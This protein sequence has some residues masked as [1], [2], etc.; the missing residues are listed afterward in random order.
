MRRRSQQSLQSSHGNA[1]P[2]AAVTPG[3]QQAGPADL[4]L[5]AEA[6][7]CWSTTWRQMLSEH[8]PTQHLPSDDF[9]SR[10]FAASAS[11]PEPVSV[12]A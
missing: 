4:P 6:Y 7:R 3:G 12:N 11:E 8:T 10:V 1:K 2:V 9:T 5:L